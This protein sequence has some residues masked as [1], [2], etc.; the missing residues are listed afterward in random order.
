ME[1]HTIQDGPIPLSG[2]SPLV[3]CRQWGDTEVPSGYCAIANLP[4]SANVI[5][6][7]GTGSN[8][9]ADANY[10][11]SVLRLADLDT[12]SR[13]CFRTSEKESPSVFYIAICR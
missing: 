13:I 1:K 11:K 8:T 10:I 2:L 4:L 5:K 3:V 12:T 7:I 9:S 6:A